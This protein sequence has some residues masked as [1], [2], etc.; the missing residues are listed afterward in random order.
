MIFFD[1]QISPGKKLASE[2]VTLL[3]FASIIGYIFFINWFIPISSV[4]IK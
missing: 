4:Y 1:K 3:I 2:L